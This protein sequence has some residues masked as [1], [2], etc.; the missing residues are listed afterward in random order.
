MQRIN[1]VDA[2]F[3]CFL[4]ISFL[5]FMHCSTDTSLPVTLKHAPDDMS[6]DVYAGDQLFTRYIYS[7]QIDVLKKPVL[8]PVMTAEGHAITRGFPLDP[9]PGERVDHPH[10]IGFWLN[11]GDVN[12]LDFWNNSN[13]VAE[14]R[15]PH[16][17]TI[18]HESIKSIKDN[19]LTVTAN[20]LN[21]DGAKLLHEKT[22][23]EF[24]ASEN[25]RIIDR[26][27]TL[28]A[29]EEPVSFKDNKEGFVAIRVT[30]ALEHPAEKP[31]TLTDAKGAAIEVP[32]M[33]N[34]LVTGCYVN[35]HGVEGLEVWGK[36]SS[37][38][39]L[40]GK[41]EGESVHVILMDHPDN[42]GYP[43]YWHARG[44]GL[45]A[46]NPLGQRVF[47]NGEEVLNFSLKSGEQVTFR[48][49]LL[50]RS[51]AIDPAAVDAMYQKFI[52]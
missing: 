41:V 38:V 15:K 1:K 11:Y 31:V 42:V 34:S 3:M 23:F 22:T 19:R 33:D 36:R 30:R 46:A 14:K 5:V 18:R 45:F 8:Y 6:V 32:V 44:Y 17:G 7:D 26:V 13:A 20:W 2:C 10:H 39:D 27:T 21:S 47:S 29:L 37:W 16:M 35:A 9:V 40:R 51:G 4:F 24:H 28:T 48:Y 12:G 50:I 52:R 43:A 25:E 49:R